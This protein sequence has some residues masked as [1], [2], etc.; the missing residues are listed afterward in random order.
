MVKFAIMGAGKIAHKFAQACIGINEYLYAIAS[1]DLGRAMGFAERYDLEKYYG[2]YQEMLQ[3]DEV[4]CVY[5]ATPMSE[6]YQNIYDCLMAGKHVLCEKSFTLN[7]KQAQTV[8][9]LAKQKG[10][11]LMEA[12]WMRFL[13][14]IQEVQ[15]VIRDGLIGDIIEMESFINMRLDFPLESRIYNPSLGGGALLDVGVYPVHMANLILGIPDSFDSEVKFAST[16][17][18]IDEKITY[19]Y[20]HTDATLY[21]SVVKEDKKD[22]II[23]GS[24]G[25]IHIPHF[26]GTEQALVF[27]NHHKIIKEIEHKHLVNGFEYEIFETVKCIKKK[28]VESPIL[29]HQTTIEI[30]KQMDALRKSWNLKYPQES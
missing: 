15:Q 2:S 13:P 26:W 6:H 1:R 19:L 17:V 22:T 20:P 21:A 7:H 11:F 18:D 8:C 23:Y 10:L 3:D 28:L 27:N 9:A 16:G 25:Y 14:T 5:I 4:D 29:P 24:K 12:M 30:M